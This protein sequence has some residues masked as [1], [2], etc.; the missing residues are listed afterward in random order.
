VLIEETVKFPWSGESFSEIIRGDSNKLA[1]NLKSELTQGFIKGTSVQKM[2]SN[3]AK[4]M[5]NSYKNALRV[6]RTETAHVLNKAALMSYEEMG[7]THIEFLAVMDGRTSAICFSLNGDIIP[8]KDAVIGVN[9]PPLHP[10]CRSTVIPVVDDEDIEKPVKSDTIYSDIDAEL[11]DKGIK[12]EI[13][14]AMKPFPVT[15]TGIDPHA[16]KRLEQR[17]ITIEEAQKFVDEAIIC[18]EQN[19]GQK[20]AFYSRSGASVVLKDGKLITVL[21][22][23]NFDKNA[24]EIIKVVS[25]YVR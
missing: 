20:H 13:G 5:D 12:A 8:I 22:E 24:Q 4:R 6:V 16:R 19:K 14:K 18:F 17:G 9:T 25:K 1:R 10:N 3:I 21:K 23:E 7:V 2:S 15:I 11:R